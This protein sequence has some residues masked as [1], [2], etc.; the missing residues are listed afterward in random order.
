MNLLT[1]PLRTTIGAKY[2]MAVTGLLLTVFVLG[3]MAGNLLIFAG[4]DAL[5]SYA[6]ALKSKPTLL[7]TVRTGLLLTFLL[8]LY[9]AFR[10]SALKRAARP[11]AY[12]FEDTVAATWASRNMM[13]TGLVLLVFILYH[14]AHFTF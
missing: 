1:L 4:R 3:H 2:V 6:E 13:L 9:L 14:L 11:V 5:N 8:H 10:L 12:H 7:W